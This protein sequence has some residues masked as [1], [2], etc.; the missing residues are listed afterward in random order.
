MLRSVA[1]FAILSGLS[2]G[3]G[4][5]KALLVTRQFGTS[6]EIDA[7]NLAFLVPNLI[8]SLLSAGAVSGLV[9]LFVHEDFAGGENSSFPS[10]LVSMFVL[11]TLLSLGLWFFAQEIVNIIDTSSSNM[12]VLLSSKLLKLLAPFLFLGALN[13]VLSARLLSRRRYY[14]A[15]LLPALPVLIQVLLLFGLNARVEALAIG[16][17]VGSFLQM[18]LGVVLSDVG[19]SILRPSGP[20]LFRAL[21]SQLPFF[22]ISIFGLTNDLVDNM[23]SAYLPF[24][25]VA[26]VGYASSLMS[27][28]IRLTL[29]S[30]A[31]VALTE[32]SFFVARS[33]LAGLSDVLSRTLKW[34]MIFSIP[35]SIFLILNAQII[36]QLLFER[37]R[38]TSAD[39]QLV[40]LIF[41]GYL[42]G[43][44]PRVVGTI[45]A[46]T[47]ASLQ[48]YGF[49]FRFGLAS[50]AINIFCDYVGIR[51]LGAA[52][53]SVAT[54][55]TYI[56]S[57]S[58]L[59]L[60]ISGRLP[61]FKLRVLMEI[62]LKL[63]VVASFASIAF[64]FLARSLPGLGMVFA[65]NIALLAVFIASVHLLNVLDEQDRSKIS[66]IFYRYTASL[67]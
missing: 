48:A 63:M 30:I 38:F 44:V 60:H 14:A 43:L 17:S 26:A 57:T 46:R 6:Y 1:G 9:P 49:L 19:L 66:S 3:F 11:A 10:A 56:I 33:D 12:R 59:L 55:I 21:L 61:S 54:S 42:V 31:A 16:L 47:L 15:A 5:V 8:V 28:I 39:T 18:I 27:I 36:V 29:E 24:G 23:F 25:T 62:L 4:F 50:V 45:V 13:A 34:S 40:H 41:Q 32:F 67:R 64:L 35:L 52:G 65:L 58:F 22:G 53:I 37:G 51:F 20:A 2:F 7:F